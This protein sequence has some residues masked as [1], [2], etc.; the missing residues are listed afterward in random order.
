[1]AKNSIS[2]GG[3][4]RPNG[5][6]LHSEQVQ[7]KVSCRKSAFAAGNWQ[8]KVTEHQILPSKKRAAVKKIPVLRAM[9]KLLQNKLLLAAIL[10]SFILDLS[11]LWLTASVPEYT[12][13]APSTLLLVLTITMLL[14]SGFILLTVVCS[15]RWHGAE[16]KVINAYT[17]G[18]ALSLEN[19]KNTPRVAARCG[20]NLMFYVIPISILLL[21]AMEAIGIPQFG[22]IVI[23]LS[24]ALSLEIMDSKRLS[25]T[26]IYRALESLQ[27]QIQRWITTKEPADWQLECAIAAMNALLACEERIAAKKLT[28]KI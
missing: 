10:F 28:D 24:I 7:A 5:L 13:A 26:R 6:T 23:L 18:K 4:A 27:G 8:V 15:F 1:M 20:T 17:A 14:F 22:S 16:H 2:I 21:E 11:D 19:V 25:K 9:Y 12:S 3:H